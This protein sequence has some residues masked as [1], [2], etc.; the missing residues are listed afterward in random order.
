M[1][2]LYSPMSPFARK[3]RVVAHEAGLADRVEISV[4]RPFEDEGVRE[5]NPLS[6]VPCMLTDDPR[7]LRATR[8]GRLVLD[9]LTSELALP[10]PAGEVA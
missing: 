8:A 4:V 9:R 3:V 2:L 6:K 7:R 1:Q 10:P 5:V